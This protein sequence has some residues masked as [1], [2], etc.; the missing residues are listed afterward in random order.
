MPTARLALSTP[1]LPEVL[2]GVPHRP[3]QA[4]G[5]EESA[6]EGTAQ[7]SCWHRAHSL[8]LQGQT[9]PEDQPKASPRELLGCSASPGIHIMTEQVQTGNTRNGISAQGNCHCAPLCIC[10]YGCIMWL[11]I[12]STELH[13][14][15][16]YSSAQESVTAIRRG[17]TSKFLPIK[18]N[19]TIISLDHKLAPN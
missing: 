2:Q 15:K 6:P 4:K 12:K 8:D 16:Q 7:K 11:R 14:R 3:P 17:S 18:S 13:A 19:M 5:E 10:V 9:V 1:F